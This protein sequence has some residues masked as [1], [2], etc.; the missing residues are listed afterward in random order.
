MI[1]ATLVH[2]IF[3]YS[4][5]PQMSSRKMAD[6]YNISIYM[7]GIRAT[8][9]MDS[10][11]R[12]MQ[13][14]PQQQQQQQQHP[15]LVT[16]ATLAEQGAAVSLSLSTQYPEMQPMLTGKEAVLASV[17]RHMKTFEPIPKVFDLPSW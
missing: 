3:I 14:Q 6:K 2:L 12:Q 16:G 7:Q 1:C 11:M 15:Q 9:A 5:F 10:I 8:N 4:V 13:E 17:S